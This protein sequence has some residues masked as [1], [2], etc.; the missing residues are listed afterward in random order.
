MDN[1]IGI[2]GGDRGSI[3]HTVDVIMRDKTYNIVN[4]KNM[5][6][7][8]LKSALGKEE[9]DKNVGTV[10]ASNS[11]KWKKNEH[12]DTIKSIGDQI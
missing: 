8:N 12:S 6:M 2:V 7:K 10:G 3:T 4:I 11:Y 1:Y 5:K 9:T